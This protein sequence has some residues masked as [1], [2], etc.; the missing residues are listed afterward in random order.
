MPMLHLLH[1]AD[2]F[3]SAARLREL[4]VA[5]DPSGFNAVSLE[6]QEPGIDGLRAACDALS[7]FGGGRVVEARGL[8]TRWKERK[9]DGEKGKGSADAFEALAAY[10]P[11]LPPTTTLLLWEPGLFEP[12]ASLRRALQ[13]LGKGAAIERFDPPLGRPLRDWAIARAAESG[14]ILRPDAA[15]AMLDALCPQGWYEV[16]RGRD[17]TPPDLRRI[18][19]EVQKLATAALSRDPATITIRHVVAL[20]VGETE[21]NVF[22]LVDAAAAGDARRALALLKSA[23]EDGIAPELVLSL[24][25]SRFSL[26]ARVRAVGGGRAAEAA[27]SQLGVT[28][29]RAKEAARQLAQLG[30][31]RVAPCLR[32]VLEAD[33]AIKTGRAPRSDDALYWA[34]MEL[35]RLGERVPLIPAE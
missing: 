34:V 19:T 18:E 13:A 27:A 11:Q 21:T 3:R 31:E 6:A 20:T 32:I 24:L 28:P 7:F 26:I 25:A 29:Y 30:E 12:P 2:A 22:Q 17:A 1:G 9:G 14:A 8:L 23:L 16:P 35:C 4:R 15:E 33:E 5:L 10:L